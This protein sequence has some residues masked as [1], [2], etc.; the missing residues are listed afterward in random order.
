MGRPRR[1][2]GLSFLLSLL[3]APC[4][5]A[6]A[7]E[8]QS[9]AA[10]RAELIVAAAQLDGF[11]VDREWLARLPFKVLPLS[12]KMF[13]HYEPPGR[14]GASGEI[15][16]NSTI[17]AASLR[18]LRAVGFEEGEAVRLLAWCI[19]PTV[20]HEAQHA[21]QV[22]QYKK[23]GALDVYFIE[24][25]IEA[26]AV[27]T[28]VYLQVLEKRPD[29]ARFYM[30]AKGEN[31]ADLAVWREGIGPFR[32]SIVKA[33]ASMIPIPSL[34][35]AR[36]HFSGQVAQLEEMAAEI[37]DL[38]RQ[39]KDPAERASLEEHL[40][41]LRESLAT[42]KDPRVLEATIGY[43]REQGEHADALWSEWAKSDPQT[44][45]AS[46]PALPPRERARL[47]MKAAEQLELLSPTANASEIERFYAQARADAVL[48]RDGGLAMRIGRRQS[49]LQGRRVDYALDVVRGRAASTDDPAMLAQILEK[50]VEHLR[51]HLWPQHMRLIEEE[52]RAALKR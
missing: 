50:N 32:E 13:A 36:D 41:G 44:R 1:S 25:E 33:Y 38:R 27:G 5:R 26:A 51:A 10:L 2:R 21:E 24:S 28:S 30:P 23:R 9:P 37:E 4:A 7:P 11:D 19:L 45:L 17:L 52:A 46:E 34:A 29:M 6:A 16:V 31:A 40:K 39:S 18:S 35:T 22:D 3:L 48:A 8:P 14:D 42:L 12:S 20:L 49:S 47:A 43:I 15:Q